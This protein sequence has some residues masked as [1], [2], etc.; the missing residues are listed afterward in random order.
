MAIASSTFTL[1]LPSLGSSP[2]PFKGRA[3]IGLAPVLKARKTSATTLSRE[4]LISHS[5]KL[6]HSLLKKSGDAGIGD[7]GI[8]PFWLTLFGKQQANVFNSEKGDAGMAPMWVTVFGS[9]R[10]VFN[11]EKGDAGMAPVWVTVFGSERGVFN[12]EKGDAGMAPVWGDGF[13][14][15]ERCF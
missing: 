8:P 10:G 12:S 13:W 3:H 2:S 7:D 15:R 4:T 11:S 5:S 14:L 1:A 6:H 9:E